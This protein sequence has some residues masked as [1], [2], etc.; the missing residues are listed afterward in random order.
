MASARAGRARQAAHDPRRSGHRLRPAGLSPLPRLGRG[1]RGGRGLRPR[2]PL[3]QLQGGD[4]QRALPRALADHARRD[5]G[6]R[7][8]RR[9]ARARQALQ[10]GRLHHRLLPQRARSDEGDHRGG[11]PRGQLLRPPASRQ[12]PRGLRRASPRSSRPRARTAPSSPISPPSSR[13]CASTARSSSCSRAGSSTSSR[14]PRR[15]SSTP[16]ASWWTRSAAASRRRRRA[17]RP[18]LV[19]SRAP[20]TTISSSASCGAACSPEWVRSPPSSPTRIA[21]VI[22]ERVFDEDPPVRLMEDSSTRLVAAEGGDSPADPGYAPV[23]SPEGADH[24]GHDA[25]AEKPELFVGAAFAGGLLVAGVLRYLGDDAS[26]RTT[27][28][29]RTSARSSRRSPRRPRCWCARRSSSRR[30][31]SRRRSRR[32]ARGRRWEPPPACSSCSP[33]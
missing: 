14:A 10:G 28:P 16:R 29:T 27:E 20:W 18:S 19:E 33:S 26:H 8:A 4:P 25:F 23:G 9:R 3:L 7:L 24:A 5:R 31:R 2:L 12:D 22:W 17:H 13:R 1:R 30:P 21:A 15:S 11:H 32:S 6:D